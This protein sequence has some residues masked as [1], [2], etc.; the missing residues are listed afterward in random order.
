MCE[1]SVLEH[2]E[3]AEALGPKHVERR[4]VPADEA[5]NLLGALEPLRP[6]IPPD[7]VLLETGA[8]LFLRLEEGNDVRRTDAPVP[9]VDHRRV[10]LVPPRRVGDEIGRN[11]NPLAWLAQLLPE[12]DLGCPIKRYLDGTCAAFPFAR[13]LVDGARGGDRV[14]SVDCHCPHSCSCVAN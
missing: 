9:A 2:A 10:V 13:D 4:V 6:R 11:A 5:D 7:V 3:K 12:I 8:C 14:E 1:A